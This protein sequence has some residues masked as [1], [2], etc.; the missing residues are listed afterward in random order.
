MNAKF[1][2]RC[3]DAEIWL[4]QM[5]SG[6]F[7]KLTKRARKILSPTELKNGDLLKLSEGK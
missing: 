1:G 2:P 5:I 6:Q 7:G 3:S 4:L